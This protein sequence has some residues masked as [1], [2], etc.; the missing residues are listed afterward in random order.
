MAI[1]ARD[2]QDI[3][4][5]LDR[6]AARSSCLLAWLGQA[7]FVIRC[8]Q[9]LM[10]IDPYLSDSL[11]EKY[12]GTTFPHVRLMPPPIAPADLVPVDAVFCTHAHTDHMDPDTLS[13]VARRNPR[14]RF[15]V[16]RAASEAAVLRGVPQ[17]RILP[18]NAGERAGVAPGISVYAVASAHEELR[19]DTEGNH[20]FLGYV[21]ETDAGV[22]YH[23][24]DCAPY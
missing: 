24:G 21:I 18:L 15:V 10:V 1:S 6:Q 16:P 17:D 20:H 19:T 22:L 23:S 13:V 4:A 5:L 14:A 2:D 8:G 3:A 7:G 11:A 12:R 9:A